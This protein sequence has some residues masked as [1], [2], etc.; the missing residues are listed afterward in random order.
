MSRLST[1]GQSSFDATESVRPAADAKGVRL[2]TVLD[3]KAG[4][5]TG[6]PNRLQQILWNLLSNAIKFTSRGGRVQIFLRRIS[7]H[8]EISVVDS[9]QGISAEFLPQLFTRF[10]QADTSLARQHG[11][12]G[13]GLAL[14]KSLVDMH[15]GSIK[16]SSPGVDQGSTFTV[17]LPLSAVHVEDTQGTHTTGFSSVSLSSAPDLTRISR[18]GR[19]R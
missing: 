9:G 4:P 6:D 7:S 19:R 11:G 14:V 12:L 1:F 2:T 18:F 13:L 8:V 5:I 3:P 10:S 15:G 17:A 16:A